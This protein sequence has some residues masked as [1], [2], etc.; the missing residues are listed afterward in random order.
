[1]SLSAL[2]MALQSGKSRKHEH[3]TEFSSA[4]CAIGTPG[5]IV[6]HGANLYRPPLDPRVHPEVIEDVVMRLGEYIRVAQA[7]DI[8]QPEEVS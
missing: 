8:S 1:V 3:G 4:R 7:K 6:L 2:G 5:T